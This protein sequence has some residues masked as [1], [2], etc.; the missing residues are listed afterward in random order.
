MSAP[1]E[2]ILGATGS[3]AGQT[4]GPPPPTDLLFV[5]RALRASEGATQSDLNAALQDLRASLGGGQ[6][7]ASILSGV[8]R[9]VLFARTAVGMSLI[10]LVR[11]EIEPIAATTFFRKK[12]LPSARL[13]MFCFVKCQTNFA[14]REFT[15]D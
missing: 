3:A 15:I 12:L 1:N 14:I 13:R 4:A 2:F 10:P 11:V 5:L 7:L 6:P 8:Q 9:D